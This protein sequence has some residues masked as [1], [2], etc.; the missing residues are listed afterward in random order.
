MSERPNPGSDEA[1]A[2]GCI[3]PVLDNNHGKFAPWPDDGWWINGDCSLHAEEFT[4]SDPDARSWNC[5]ECGHHHVGPELGG[6][7]VGCPC[8][9][10]PGGADALIV[11]GGAS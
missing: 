9:N 6:I 3:C 4:R 1:R 5:P 11:S 8:R 10:Y 2:A 7:C